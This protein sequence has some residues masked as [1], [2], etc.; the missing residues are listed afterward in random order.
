M[1]SS[2]AA[3]GSN[4]VNPVHLVKI[5]QDGAA[6][7]IVHE[8]DRRPWEGRLLTDSGWPALEYLRAEPPGQ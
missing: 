7:R 2:L 3:K 4:T 5:L 8:L 1:R 6:D